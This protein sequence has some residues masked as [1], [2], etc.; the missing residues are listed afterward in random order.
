MHRLVRYFKNQIHKKTYFCRNIPMDS[1]DNL[2]LSAQLA[3]AIKETGLT[4]PTPVQS[5]AFPV[6][7]SGRDVVGI[8]Q[9]GTGKTLAYLLPIIQNLKFSNQINP[10][11]LIL[12]P[13]RELV[14]QVVEMI[15][16]VTTYINVRARGVYGGT[17]INTQKQLVMQGSDILVATP[18]RLY[19]LAVSGALKLK[20]I[21]KL[22]IDEVDV[23]LDQGFLRQ[24]ANI[25]GLLPERRQN[26]M[27]SAT[28]TP[29]VDILIN[30][31]F[32]SPERISIAV[33]GVPLNNIV[34]QCYPVP[35]FNTKVNLLVHLLGDKATFTKVLVFVGSKSRADRLFELLQP[36]YGNEAGIIH[37]NKSQNYRIK[38]VKEFDAG[39][40]RI[41]VST[42]IMARGIDME[43]ITHVINFDTPVYPENYLHRIGRTGRA[44]QPGKSILFYSK[45][46]EYNKQAIEKLMDYK[47]PKKRFP[48]EV[49][50]STE[51]VPEERPRI[52]EIKIPRKKSADQ[53]TGTAFHEKKEKNQKTNQ[54]GSYKRTL[55][56]KYKKP[57]TRGDK[58]YNKKRKK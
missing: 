53:T 36:F 19:D 39:K 55:A 48:K 5:A 27:F 22:V 50:V 28:M 4:N 21:N 38:S 7:L 58:N 15:E 52:P 16:S 47:I 26:I 11:V 34:Q 49:E 24:F 57:K 6:I 2:K 18:G 31:Y 32:I 25:F 12:V 20:S 56:A 9:T 46:E 29:E 33:S 10:R 35:N 13:T 17:S 40:F 54:G 42:D 1:F 41:I 30:E 23:L 43:K 44:E 51:L 14:L 8:A 3:S 37:S 45:K